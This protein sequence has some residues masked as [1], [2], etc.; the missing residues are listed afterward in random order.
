MSC[1][2]FAVPY[3]LAWVIGTVVMGGVSAV[4]VNAAFETY[5]EEKN[6]NCDDIQIISDKNF[7]EKDFP[8][9]FVDKDLLIKTLEEHGV[10]DIGENEF[11]KISGKIE[12]YTLSFVKQDENQPYSL[13][14]S[15]LESDNAEEKLNDLSQ[16]YALNVQEEAYMNI[17]EKLRNNN[18]E[19]ENEEVTE[20]NTIVLTVNL[21]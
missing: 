4:Q 15:C 13:R 17:I 12:N 9:A 5:N 11:G 8:T 7:V 10:Q 16:E 19:I 14:I 1:T 21:E 18:M 3:A 20:D 6:E 2:V